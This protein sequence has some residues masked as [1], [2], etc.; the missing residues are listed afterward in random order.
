MYVRTHVRSKQLIIIVQRLSCAYPPTHQAESQSAKPHAQRSQHTLT[1]AKNKPHTDPARLRLA[2]RAP[3]QKATNIHSPHG[4][5]RRES[6][7][8][9]RR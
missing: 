5:A 4:T 6:H 1:H 8:P 7:Q 3:P 2:Q 9:K